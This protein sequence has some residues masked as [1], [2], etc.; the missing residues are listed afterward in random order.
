MELLAIIVGIRLRKGLLFLR[1]HIPVYNWQ[2][3]GKPAYRPAPVCVVVHTDQVFFSTVKYIIPYF[4]NSFFDSG[5]LFAV[6]GVFADRGSGPA[7]THIPALVRLI[8]AYMPCLAFVV[9]SK[10]SSHLLRNARISVASSDDL[11]L[12]VENPISRI[13]NPKGR[14]VPE[15]IDFEWLREYTG[16]VND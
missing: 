13:S 10:L 9:D 3:G 4:S 8:T 16:S 11:K 6:G 15:S 1:P 7:N 12:F 14:T 5:G 2:G